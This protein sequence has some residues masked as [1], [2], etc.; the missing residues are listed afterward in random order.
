MGLLVGPCDAPCRSVCSKT[1][2]LI[3]ASSLLFVRSRCIVRDHQQDRSADYSVTLDSLDLSGRRRLALAVGDH[4]RR[5]HRESGVD[6]D[7]RRGCD[8]RRGGGGTT[9][10]RTQRRGGSGGNAPPSSHISRGGSEG[11]LQIVSACILSSSGS[12]WQS[13]MS[14]ELSSLDRKL[15]L[16]AK[17]I[18][19]PAIFDGC[20]SSWLPWKTKLLKWLAVVE[21]RMVELMEI[22]GRP[23]GRIDSDSDVTKKLGVV[24]YVILTSLLEG[25]LLQIVQAV[26]QRAG[27]EVWKQVLRNGTEVCPSSVS[28]H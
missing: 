27:F 23:D 28:S 19:K 10:L 20:E 1:G 11:Y 4:C 17:L 3:V 5:G 15:L 8:C 25:R 2:F 13:D 22:V 24:L 21:P 18:E 7:C 6:G 12:E 14:T 26:E 9:L 16:E